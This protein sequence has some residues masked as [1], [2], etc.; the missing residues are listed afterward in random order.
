MKSSYLSFV[1]QD[2][3]YLAN[4][5]PQS[6][7]IDAGGAEAN[8]PYMTK[9]VAI[10]TAEYLDTLDFFTMNKNLWVHIFPGEHHSYYSWMR[11]AWK[12]L[13]TLLPAEGSP[14]MP[15]APDASFV[16]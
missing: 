5:P 9:Q 8:E 14:R 3:R 6:I 11:R 10:E 12:A 4:R 2:S 13:V 15:A 1:L 16:G 7:Y